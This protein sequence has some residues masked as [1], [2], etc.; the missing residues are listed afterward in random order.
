MRHKPENGNKERKVPTMSEH[1]QSSTLK[2][3]HCGDVHLDTPCIGLSPEKSEERRNG[4]RSTFMRMMEYVRDGGVDYMLI[5]GDLFNTECATN[6]T[7]ELLSRE[8]PLTLQRSFSFASSATAPIQSLL[9]LPV[10]PITMRITRSTPRED[11]LRTAT[12]SRPI[13]SPALI[14]MMT[15]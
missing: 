8:A 11:F 5:S 3:L 15:E 4:L 9:S 1:N 10:D 2:F 12:Y 7:A 6:S 13:S 14:L